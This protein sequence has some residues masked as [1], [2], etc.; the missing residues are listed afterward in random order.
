[1][2]VVI[3]GIMSTTARYTEKSLMLMVDRTSLT[4]LK[5]LM[6]PCRFVSPLICTSVQMG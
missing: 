6:V 4:F 2:T 3:A 5:M 1:M